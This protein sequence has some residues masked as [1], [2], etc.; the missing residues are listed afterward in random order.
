MEIGR[1]GISPE[2]VKAICTALPVNE[3]WLLT[4]HG[5]MTDKAPIDRENIKAR[6]KQIRKDN[7]LTQEEFGQALGYSKLNICF[8]ETGRVSPS[9]PLIRSICSVFGVRREW[10]LTGVGEMYPP[11]EELD[12]ELITWLKEHPEVIRELKERSG[13]R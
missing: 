7:R 8:V 9:D 10:L 13:R 1:S 11:P 12:D 3:E 5:E 6:I 4:G 2:T